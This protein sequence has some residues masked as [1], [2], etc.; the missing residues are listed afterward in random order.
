MFADKA[1]SLPKSGVSEKCCSVKGSGLTR[2]RWARLGKFV[3]DKHSGLLQIFV[4]YHR[5]KFYDTDPGRTVNIIHSITITWHS[6]RVCGR[7]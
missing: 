2:K 4:N 1:G 3:E 5:N 7:M 6:E